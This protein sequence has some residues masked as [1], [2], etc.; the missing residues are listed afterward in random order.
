MTQISSS[1]WRAEPGNTCGRR[2]RMQIRQVCIPVRPPHQTPISHPSRVTY[3][4]IHAPRPTFKSPYAY[5][6]PGRSDKLRRHYCQFVYT[7]PDSRQHEAQTPCTAALARSP[8]GL[9]ASIR[10]LSRSWSRSWHIHLQSM[11]LKRFLTNIWINGNLEPAFRGSVERW[12]ADPGLTPLSIEVPCG[13][14]RLKVTCTRQKYSKTSRT[15]YMIWKVG[16]RRWRTAFHYPIPIS[17]NGC[18]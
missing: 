14:G 9:Q 1:V 2:V 4:N 12:Q 8:R 6:C 7:P 18:D 3:A 17:R 15:C 16:T 10:R 13:L 5:V 11:P